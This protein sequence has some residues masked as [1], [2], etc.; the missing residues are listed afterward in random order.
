METEHKSSKR[1]LMVARSTSRQLP[2][3]KEIENDCL[4]QMPPVPLEEPMTII[5]RLHLLENRQDELELQLHN[6]VHHDT[7]LESLC[8]VS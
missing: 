2:H 8:N 6:H 1:H 7:C 3:F 5:D 4:E